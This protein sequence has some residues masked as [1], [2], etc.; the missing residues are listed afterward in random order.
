MKNN[1]TSS[2]KYL[3]NNSSFITPNELHNHT[4][5]SVFSEFF[6][7]FF[8][9]KTEMVTAKIQ[10]MKLVHIYINFFSDLYLNTKV[11]GK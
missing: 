11:I 2:D 3:A 8:F 10:E 9:F 5:F 7:F 4:I 1:I 6:F